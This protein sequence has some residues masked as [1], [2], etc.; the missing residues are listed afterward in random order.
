VAGKKPPLGEP[1]HFTEA[2]E[3]FRQRTPI[4]APDFEKLT[5]DAKRRAFKV[6]GVAQ[7]DLVA[8]AW[9]ALEKAIA[10]G[11]SL[12]DFKKEARASLEAAWASSGEGPAA[13]GPRMDV[14]FRNNVQ[15]AYSA[16]RY[17]QQTK[18]DALA[19]RPFWAFDSIADWRRS[20][21]CAAC[22]G[23]V[24]RADHPWWSTHYP[25]LH[26][27]CRSSVRAYTEEEARAAGITTEPTEVAAQE[28]W[29]EP[30]KEWEPDLSDVPKPLASVYRRKRKARG[31]PH[32]TEDPVAWTEPPASVEDLQKRIAAIGQDL[33]GAKVHTTS[34]EWDS[35]RVPF[36]AH[37]VCGWESDIRLSPAASTEIRG[38]LAEAIREHAVGDWQMS[39]LVHENLHALGE[40]KKPRVGAEMTSSM[41]A[42]SMETGRILEEGAVELGAVRYTAEIM[43][44][45]GFKLN[46]AHVSRR[47]P[48]AWSGAYLREVGLVEALCHAAGGQLDE[49]VG[50]LL[51]VK[52]KD[53]HMGLLHRWDPMKRQA[54]ISKVLAARSRGAG[55]D[56]GMD[57]ER[58]ERIVFLIGKLGKRGRYPDQDVVDFRALLSKVMKAKTE[59]EV[60][61]LVPYSP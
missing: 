12:Q 11:S 58:R 21:I 25:P 53:A 22:Q 41:L 45:A 5:A 4:P 6:A 15:S 52:A 60:R 9:R 61:A 56:A 18:P 8:D 1:G 27:Q 36:G 29:G 33:F 20:K 31:E 46:P 17:A 28:G 39:T 30:L 42:Y 13:P 59:A 19:R 48:G 14:I 50:A 10:T 57:F 3:W 44:R 54:E 16:G 32:P 37:A 38:V 35:K 24:L 43:E 2:V 49:P 51:N 23:V 47:R 40:F 26:H 34:V 55:K 7:L